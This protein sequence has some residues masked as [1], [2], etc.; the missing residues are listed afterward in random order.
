[1]Y[2]AMNRF[3]VLKDQAHAFEEVWK[4][5]VSRLDEMRGFVVFHLL[6]GPEF[7]DHIL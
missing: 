6:K 1:M 7:E 3:K 5:R 2:I 4:S